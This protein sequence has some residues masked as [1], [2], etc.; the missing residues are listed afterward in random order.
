[1]EQ[2]TR[3][4]ETRNELNGTMKDVNPKPYELLETSGGH[5]QTTKYDI[6]KVYTML[7]KHTIHPSHLISFCNTLQCFKNYCNPTISTCLF[8]SSSSSFCFANNSSFPART[9]SCSHKDGRRPQ[10]WMAA[11]RMDGS[12][13]DGRRPHGNTSNRH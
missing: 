10:G 11:T 7:I 4:I 1:M 5:H 2:E 8:L 9:R 3:S 13:K 12:H 6:V